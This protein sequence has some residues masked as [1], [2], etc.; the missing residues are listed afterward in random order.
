MG[1][2]VKNFLP[3]SKELSNSWN[4]RWATFNGFCLIFSTCPPNS[5]PDRPSCLRP[6]GQLTKLIILPQQLKFLELVALNQVINRWSYKP[7][8]YVLQWKAIP[9]KSKRLEYITKSKWK[10]MLSEMIVQ[11]CVAVSINICP[12]PNLVQLGIQR[13]PLPS[14]PTWNCTIFLI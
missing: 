6:A 7:V 12:Q 11:E 13:W 2:R 14:D 1:T 10:I 8:T 9:T 3:C 4:V 5:P